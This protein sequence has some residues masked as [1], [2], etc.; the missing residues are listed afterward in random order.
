MIYLFKKGCIIHDTAL[1]GPV[2]IR[3][4]PA[5]LGVGDSFF[6]SEPGPH[7]GGYFRTAHFFSEVEHKRQIGRIFG[8]EEFS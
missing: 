1:W 3:V 6:T 8:W 5:G 7:F 4:I 2:S